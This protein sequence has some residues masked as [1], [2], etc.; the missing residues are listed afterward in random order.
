MMVEQFK[1]VHVCCYLVLIAKCNERH[2]LT[3]GEAKGIGC[4][5]IEK[6]NCEQWIVLT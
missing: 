2:K 6:A 3:E 5:S 1:V 4:C